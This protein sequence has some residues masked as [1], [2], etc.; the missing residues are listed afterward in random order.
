VSLVDDRITIFFKKIFL[1]RISKNIDI[2]YMSENENTLDSISNVLSKKHIGTNIVYGRLNSELRSAIDSKDK[3]KIIY[4]VSKILLKGVDSMNRHSGDRVVHAQSKQLYDE[5]LKYMCQ[6]SFD[7]NETDIRTLRNKILEQ[8]EKKSG[9]FN[10]SF[11]ILKSEFYK[12]PDGKVIVVRIIERSLRSVVKRCKSGECNSKGDES[13]LLYEDALKYLCCIVK[14]KSME[15]EIFIFKATCEAKLREEISNYKKAFKEYK[16][17]K[18]W[19]KFDVKLVNHVQDYLDGTV[20]NIEE[21]FGKISYTDVVSLDEL[22]KHVKIFTNLMNV[23]NKILTSRLNQL[24]K[25]REIIDTFDKY[26]LSPDEK[27]ELKNILTR[28]YKGIIEHDYKMSN[29]NTILF[30]NLIG[31]K[32]PKKE[33]KSLLYNLKILQVQ[34][35]SKK[36]RK[37]VVFKVKGKSELTEY[38]QKIRNNDKVD[39][40]KLLLYVLNN[41]EYD[42]DKKMNIYKNIC[43]ILKKCKRD[44]K[45]HGELYDIQIKLRNN[46][47]KSKLQEIKRKIKKK[48]EYKEIKISDIF[49]INNIKL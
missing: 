32:L 23:Y 9:K 46:L 29:S 41:H 12:N 36:R 38:I 11:G 45:T 5:S 49:E 31:Y 35:K 37:F 13:K 19:I 33:K 40:K 44:K 27:I 16:Y 14:S 34:N 26:E 15:S 28:I 6:K 17:L 30:K 21:E 24:K 48:E 8:L 10:R 2:I 22:N 25:L 3:H 47:V 42:I 1:Q 4:I 20:K 7:C 18:D 39:L 43:S